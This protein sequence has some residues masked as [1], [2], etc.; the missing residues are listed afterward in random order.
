MYLSQ[1]VV[2]EIVYTLH[3]PTGVADSFYFKA[4][5]YPTRFSHMDISATA[6]DST[7]KP[8]LAFVV[9]GTTIATGAAA[10]VAAD[11]VQRT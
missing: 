1:R 5:N 9:D 11:T 10:V 4:P 8:T 2:P 7:D 6:A 3:Q